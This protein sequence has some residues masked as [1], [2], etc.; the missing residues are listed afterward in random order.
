M[1]E[2]APITLRQA[3]AFVFDHHRNHPKLGGGAVF[4]IALLRWI[5]GSQAGPG[6]VGVVIAG[7]PVAGGL[8]DGR[9]LEVL[10][11]CVLE[12]VPNGCSILYRAAVRAGEAM[13]YHRF[14]TYTLG[15]E[16]GRSLKAAGF[17]ATATTRGGAWSRVARRRERS[18]HE[19]PKVRWEV[20]AGAK[21]AEGRVD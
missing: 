2:V 13:G 7:R 1:L 16:H 15:T 18:K 5:P 9:T 3:R 20:P 14:I 11:C 8:Q 21:S 12:G 6:L 19:G 10:R 17:Q 4:A